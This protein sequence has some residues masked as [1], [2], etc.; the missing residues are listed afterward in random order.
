MLII[1]KGNEENFKNKRKVYE[2][3][4]INNIIKKSDNKISIKFYPNYGYSSTK[5]IIIIAKKK[6]EN[7]ENNF[8]N[9][10]YL[11]KLL[12]GKTKEVKIINIFDIGEKDLIE[13]DVDIR[14]IDDK[15]N[16]N[17]IVNIISQELRFS[18]SMNLYKPKIFNIKSGDDDD[19]ENKLLIILAISLSCITF[20]LIVIGIIVFIKK[21][22]EYDKL[23]EQVN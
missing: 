21:K 9:P 8:S 12:S 17:Y 7:S 3:L 5:Y 6:G 13:A 2:N 4:S 20:I 19:N 1:I 15:S 14:D 23:R 16:G 18:K 22:S 11:A 10:C